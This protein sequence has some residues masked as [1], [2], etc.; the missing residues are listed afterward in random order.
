MCAPAGRDALGL[1]TLPGAKT[2]SQIAAARRRRRWEPPGM[3]PGEA[4]EPAPCTP[5]S[6][7]HVKDVGR[8][9]QKKRSRQ[10]QRFMARKALLQEQGL[11]SSAPG[12]PGPSQARGAAPASSW[13]QHLQVGTGCGG[14]C[15][16]RPTGRAAPGPSKC[17]A[18]DC[19]MV[20][21]GPR[22]RVSELA[23][24]S[25]VS[26]HGDVL[27][28]KY[29]LPEMPVTD[30]RTRWS[31]ITRQHMRRAIP[32]QV[33][34]SEILKLLK[35]KVVVGHALHNDFRALKYAHPRSHTRDTTRVPSLLGQ[36]GAQARTRVSL[37]DLA[38]HLLNKKIQVGRHGHSSVEDAATAM[39]L[40]RLVEARWEEQEAG[41]APAGPQDWGPDSST[42]LEQFMEDR[43]WPE[44]LAQD[45]LRS[46]GEARGTGE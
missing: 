20:G 19:E 17:V 27:Y 8:R 31:G 41:R 23:R 33:A 32:F 7:L 35:G 13:S 29:V 10:H 9:R 45:A 22:G 28:D 26:Y 18:V 38:L 42:D 15:R 5:L 6:G 4:P 3:L 12:Q 16:E 43:Y 1:S 25:V 37:K 44:E 2:T 24:C 11:L 14:P 34:R 40:Y 36:P 46:S 30:Y 39:E 21:T